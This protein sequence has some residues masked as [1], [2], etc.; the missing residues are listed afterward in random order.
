MNL[1]FFLLR[2][3]SEVWI[4]RTVPAYSKPRTRCLKQS[5]WDTLPPQCHWS[6]RHGNKGTGRC[7]V[8][9][10]RSFYRRV[11]KE[12]RKQPCLLR[13]SN[14]KKKKIQLKTT[15]ENV[16]RYKL[17]VD[18]FV[19]CG[20]PLQETEIV[21]STQK[22]LRVYKEKTSFTEIYCI[23]FHYIILFTW[24]RYDLCNVLVS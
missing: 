9:N 20:L 6:W 3:V 1:Q 2:Y 8:Q 13:I 18:K 5:D 14:D 12:L 19:M 24:I 7:C 15:K 17:K 21:F 23:Y 22:R 10:H 4:Y 11:S 16:C